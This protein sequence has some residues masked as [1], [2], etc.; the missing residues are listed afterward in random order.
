MPK[1]MVLT[2]NYAAAYGAWSSRARVVAA[3]PI[4]PQTSIVEK[5]AELVETGVMDAKYIR[6]ESEHS[7]MAACIG[8][9]AMGVR[10]FTA[11]SS[12]GLAYMHEMLHWAARARLPIVM[13][14]VNRAMGPPWNIWTDHTDTMSQRDTGWIQA[15]ASNNQEVYDLILQAY[16]VGEHPDVR[17]PVMVC[18]DAFILSHTSTPVI[19]YTPEEAD[20]FLPPYRPAWRLDPDN[21]VT[22]GNIVTP[23]HYY[24]FSWDIQ[25]GMENAKKVIEEVDREYEKFSG[26]GYG[27][28][29]QLYKVEDAEVLIF[30]LGTLAEEAMVAAERLRKEGVKAGVVKVRFFR[31]FPAEQVRNLSENVE[32]I[33]VLDRAVSYGN[34]GQLATEVKATL[35]PLERKPIVANYVVGLG[36]RDVPYTVI[37]ELV[38]KTVKL[39]KQ[40]DKPFFAQLK[41]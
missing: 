25:R 10:S 9:E 36:G 20:S 31:P 33:A 7:A 22:S 30:A 26:R 19:V 35:Y 6:V 15:Y 13:A 3:Y 41:T 24:E 17:L 34:E 2:G 28:L 5:I 8:A 1:A 11:T 38:K 14:V 27:G 40:P 18:L 32:K 23:E 16:R 4:T 12:Q 37:E 39:D 21:P 29:L